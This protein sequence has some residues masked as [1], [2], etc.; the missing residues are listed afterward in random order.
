MPYLP[1]VDQV[2]RELG[3]SH[4]ELS[5]LLG[6]GEVGEPDLLQQLRCPEVSWFG[7]ITSNSRTIAFFS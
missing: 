6:V 2:N 5:G 1:V 7:M 3:S 4:H